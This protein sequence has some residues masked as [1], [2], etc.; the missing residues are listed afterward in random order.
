MKAKLFATLCTLS[1]LVIAILGTAF[2][3]TVTVGVSLGN[4]LDYNYSLFWNS[5]D[6]TATVPPE[7]IEL[8]NTQLIQINIKNV[9]GTL[10]NMD[11]TKHFRNGTETTQ[12][13]NI[14]VDKQIID[15]PYGF[16]IIRANANPSEKI[17]PSGGHATITETIL[18]TY[19]QGT[20]KTNHYISETTTTDTYEK[21]EIY[22]DKATGVSTEYYNELRETS[23]SYVTTAKE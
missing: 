6:P 17:Y 5:T 15:I 18:R 1:L 8:N 11:I 9:S 2:A 22:F 10:I 16:L 21:M 20:R 4:I 19:A 3:Q 14:D 23:D 12:N 13:G 7:Y